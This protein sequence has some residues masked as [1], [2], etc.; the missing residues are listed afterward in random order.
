MNKKIID[1]LNS[2]GNLIKSVNQSKLTNPEKE[3]IFNSGSDAMAALANPVDQ[4]RQKF[5]AASEVIEDLQQP[6]KQSQETVSAAE[7]MENYIN[8]LVDAQYSVL[9]ATIG[10]DKGDYNKKDL[11]YTISGLIAS[12]KKV[13]PNNIQQAKEILKAAILK[14]FREKVPGDRTEYALSYINTNMQ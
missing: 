8:G 13:Y 9:R 10:V 6:S 7:P 12:I 5:V 2:V 4:A 3:Q 11:E 1:I 14:D